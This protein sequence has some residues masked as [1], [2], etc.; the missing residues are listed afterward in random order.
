MPW[1]D[2]TPW[3]EKRRRQQQRKDSVRPTLDAI[4]W[5]VEQSKSGQMSER[6]A[7]QEIE[8]LSS[9]ELDAIVRVPDGKDSL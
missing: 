3:A 6:K 1:H 7:L 8:Q 5:L 2:E 9:G 4:A